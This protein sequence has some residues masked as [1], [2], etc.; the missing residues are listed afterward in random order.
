M[1]WQG[2]EGE[3]AALGEE[4]GAEGPVSALFPHLLTG[5]SLLLFSVTALGTDLEPD[6]PGL[7]YSLSH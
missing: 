1:S 4:K 7:K 3:A 2:Q 6:T 5:S